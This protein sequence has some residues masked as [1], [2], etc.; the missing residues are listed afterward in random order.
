[1]VLIYRREVV[2]KALCVLS[3][4]LCVPLWLV[5][6]QY[7]QGSQRKAQSRTMEKQSTNYF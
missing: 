4:N 7:N 3:E 1:M 5:L 2:S 6:N